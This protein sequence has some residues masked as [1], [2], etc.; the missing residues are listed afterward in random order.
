MTSCCAKP[1][2]ADA[3]PL[4][5]LWLIDSLTV[6]GAESLVVPFVRR[7]DRSRI[8]LSVGCL[9]T[10]SGNAIEQELQGD[11]VPMVNLGARNLRDIAAFRRLLRYIRTEKIDLIHA[12][13]AYA[14]TW[15]AVASR[16]TGVPSLASLHVAPPTG[17]RQEI[18]DRLMRFALNRW[19]SAVVA[20]SGALRDDYLA[21][22]SLDRS[23]VWVVHNGIDIHRFQP[24][25]GR[26]RANV[27]REFGIAPGAPLVATVSVLRPGK[28]IEVLL[29]AV[30]LIVARVPAAHFL[31]VGDGPMRREWS[32]L[33]QRLGIE[34]RVHWAGHRSDVDSI[35]PAADLL[36]HPT[37]A[38][39]FP[40]VL[41][42]AMAAG[43]PVVASQV[44]GIPEIVEPGGTGTLVPASNPEAL[45]SAVVDLLMHGDA[46]A[47]MGRRAREIATQRFSTEAWLARL[48]TLYGE[49]LHRDSQT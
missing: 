41:L 8:H 29:D 15:A 2:E 13:L 12:H 35:L 23:K 45:A 19:S 26:S 30:P 43:L 48:N 40:T 27:E 9:T 25:R 44:G 3:R 49:V 14:A 10:I 47:G 7:H 4:R 6:G 31:I 34:H 11:N 1:R 39:A 22:G 28:G 5:L 17:G 37:L 24:D 32:E 36:V 16:I 21:T 46:R 38:D 33:A 20:V 18:R 42:E